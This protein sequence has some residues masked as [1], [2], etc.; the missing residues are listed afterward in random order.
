MRQKSEILE[1]IRLHLHMDTAQMMSDLTGRMHSE[2]DLSIDKVYATLSAI[3]KV[4]DK[5]VER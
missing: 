2:I 5:E 1:G 3:Q 4:P